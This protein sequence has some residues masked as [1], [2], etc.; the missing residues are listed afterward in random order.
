MHTTVKDL[1][2]SQT[3]AVLSQK[4]ICR[5]LRAFSATNVPFLPAWGGRGVAPKGDNVTFIHRFFYCRACLSYFALKQLS[6]KQA[7]GEKAR[8]GNEIKQ[9]S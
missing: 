5:D 1:N 2:D 9:N 3:F 6:L 8:F 7:Q 4:H